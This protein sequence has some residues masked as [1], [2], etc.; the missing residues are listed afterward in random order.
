MEQ[1]TM[2]TAMPESNRSLS[3]GGEFT[4]QKLWM[5]IKKSG[6]RILIFC[7]AA[8]VLMAIIGGSVALATKQNM[9]TVSTLIDF[10]FKGIEEGKDPF[11][12]TMDVT[13]LKSSHVVGRAMAALAEDGT[14][15]D[16][17]YQDEIINN[18]TIEGVIPDDIM[19]QILV[20]RQIAASNSSALTQLSN[21]KYF[22]SRYLI[23]ISNLKK[24]GLTKETGTKLLNA[25][26]TQY[27]VYFKENYT[28][29]NILSSTI[30]DVDTEEY[31]FV[32]IYDIYADQIADVINYLTVKSTEAPTFRSNETKL[33]FNDLISS[34]QVIRDLDLTRYEAYV[35]ENGVTNDRTFV[36]SYMDR[37]LN[38][39]KSQQVKAEADVKSI[40][41][42]LDSY[43]NGDIIYV[44]E[45]GSTTATGGP[46]AQYDSMHSQLITAQKTLNTLN[47][48]IADMKERIEKFTTAID[49]SGEQA[50]DA[51]RHEEI[52]TQRA[53]SISQKL[54]REVDNI[55]KTVEEYLDTEY[56]NDAVQV[57]VPASYQLN[58]TSML[59]TV[60]VVAV[61][62]EA[63]AFVIAVL[64]TF[65]KLRR[66]GQI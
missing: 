13:K 36:L 26:T 9:A 17:K 53:Q 52:A 31:D 61:M 4:F 50:G 15:I 45:N 19:Q 8:A 29:N 39:L 37:R 2:K 58:Q 40:Q 48:N 10:N 30:T 43:Q 41:E 27:V 46:T 47:M 66:K 55:N 44:T 25:I 23:T 56:F 18:M 51:L 32:E 35:V 57:A 12:R 7:L 28:E 62:I 1:E 59:K 38:S 14:V 33:S 54:S 3:N 63:V 34:L 49:P 42:A 22:P 64:W 24:C 65:V 6:V 60:L 5:L 11:G 16:K 21:L 20:I